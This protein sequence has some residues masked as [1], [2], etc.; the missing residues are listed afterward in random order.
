[1]VTPD[2]LLI[3]SSDTSFMFLSMILVQFMT[4]GLAFFYGGLVKSTSVVTIMAQNFFA[5]GVVFAVWYL[6]GFS[7]AFGPSIGGIIGDPFAFICWRSVSVH[8]SLAV[9]DNVLAPGIP[10]ILMAAYQGMFAV[11]T[12]ALMT[13]SFV[14]RFLLGPYLVFIV[15]WSLFVYVPVAHWIWGGGWMAASGAVDF[16]G[17]LVCHTTS[18]FSALAVLLVLGKRQEK[19]P[20]SPLSKRRTMTGES[21]LEHEALPHNVPFVALGTSML[22]FGWFGFNG[23]S[24]LA[25]GNLAVL[26]AVNSQIAASIAM[27]GWVIFDVLH[28]KKIGLVGACVG[29]V[30]GLATVTPA[31]G[32]I[33]TWAA[34][35]IGMIAPVVC[36]S[37][38]CLIQK[39][40]EPLYG[41]DD[42]LD[43]WGVH[44]VGG[45]VGSILIGV[46]A[47]PVE[48]IDEDTA[49]STC[50][51]PGSVSRSLKQTRIQLACAIF[52][53]VYSFFT[54]WVLIKFVERALQVRPNSFDTEDLDFRLQGEMAYV[55]HSDGLA[56]S[57]R[58]RAGTLNAE[59]DE[60]KAYSSS[61][62]EDDCD[63]SLH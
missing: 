9:G 37:S 62:D 4:P 5:L 25:S 51:N 34:G 12:P 18:G 43:V 42:A 29:A 11:I 20:E 52:V 32:Y 24:A 1:M 54:T 14:D 8:Q 35:I 22:W 45:F 7:M 19:D 49:P 27:L 59:V 10:G 2:Q 58:S 61:S 30:A 44:G 26:A 13:G 40:G 17:G 50:V 23:G 16:A 55:H 38:V 63:H 48:C 60:E 47:D 41:L 36:Y 28:G 53:A 39:Y 31:A 46:L 6:I 3:N 21:Y 15:L 57:A 33:Q 56:V